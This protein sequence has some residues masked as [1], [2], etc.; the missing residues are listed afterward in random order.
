VFNGDDLRATV[1]AIEGCM[2]AVNAATLDLKAVKKK[3]RAEGFDVAA[4]G[5]AIKEHRAKDGG[6]VQERRALVELY[7]QALGLTPMEEIMQAGAAADGSTPAAKPKV[8]DV[9]PGS[10]IDLAAKRRAA[11]TKTGADAGEGAG[12]SAGLQ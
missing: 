4:L 2:D 12:E 11:R 9:A 6:R 10:P 8:P 3:A 5:I 1:E 7:R